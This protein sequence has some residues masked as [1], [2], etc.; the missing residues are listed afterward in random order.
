MGS[1][2]LRL[3]IAGMVKRFIGA[4][5]GFARLVLVSRVMWDMRAVYRHARSEATQ[6]SRWGTHSLL[7]VKNNIHRVS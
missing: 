6:Y 4:G 2:P 7:D 1:L 3:R 5:V